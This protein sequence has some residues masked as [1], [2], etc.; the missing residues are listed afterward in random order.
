[1][2]NVEALQMTSEIQEQFAASAVPEPVVASADVP[3]NLMDAEKALYRRL[4][5]EPRGRLEQ[6]FLPEELTGIISV[7]KVLRGRED[8]QLVMRPMF[9]N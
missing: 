2:G 9:L 6:E 1:M 8:L 5:S 7:Q 3:C 4:L